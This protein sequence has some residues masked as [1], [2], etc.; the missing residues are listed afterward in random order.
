[1]T[2][3]GTTCPPLPHVWPVVSMQPFS[4]GISKPKVVT[5]ADPVM[6][7]GHLSGSSSLSQDSQ[8]IQTPSPDA[9]QILHAKLGEQVDPLEFF[10][11]KA[12]ITEERCTG[13]AFFMTNPKEQEVCRDLS[14]SLRK[15]SKW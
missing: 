13:D 5:P 12:E 7:E 4:V 1:M 15:M 2:L 14:I 8:T 6:S 10:S 3:R 9:P 11:G